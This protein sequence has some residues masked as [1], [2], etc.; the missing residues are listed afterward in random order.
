[1]KESN[2]KYKTKTG[3]LPRRI[4]TGVK[5]IFDKKT[6]AKQF[7]DFFI[8]R[9]RPYLA[10]KTQNHKDISYESFWNMRRGAGRMDI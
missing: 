5:E 4:V 7:N 9:I 10:S 1:M 2:R 3:N 8:I 6:I